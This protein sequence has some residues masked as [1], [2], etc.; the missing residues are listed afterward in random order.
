MKFKG[1]IFSGMISLLIA[2]S[3]ASAIQ[4]ERIVSLAPNMTEILFALGLGDR[5]VGVSSFCDYPAEARKKPRMGGMVNP[6]LEA[7]L[8]AK[9]DIVIMTTDGNPEGLEERLAE[10]G[11]RTYISHERRLKGLPQEITAIGRA[12]GVDH[13]ARGLAAEISKSLIS[14]RAMAAKSQK[15]KRVLFIIWPEPLIVAGPGTL[16]DD[17]I[18]IL[19]WQNIASDSKI[20]YPKFSIEEVARRAPDAIIIGRAANMEAN[21]SNLLKRLRMLDAVKQ[22][23]IFY[24]SDD[25]YRLGPRVV[26]GLNELAEHLK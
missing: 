18:G 6:S 10:R 2:C 9:P 13:R 12:L 5:I 4:P 26:R 24:V 3:P 15:S 11:I 14:L 16:I 21:S 23:R 20:N 22:G 7:I 19:G 8:S 25:L 17:A 1:I